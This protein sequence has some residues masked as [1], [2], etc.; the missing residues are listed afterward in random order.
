MPSALVRVFC[1]ALAHQALPR[2]LL[3]LQLV[4]GG[5]MSSRLAAGKRLAEAAVAAAVARG[6]RPAACTPSTV[7]RLTLRPAPVPHF[8]RYHTSTVPEAKPCPR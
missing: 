2:G 5:C 1:R 8:C 3:L 4:E 6:P 7:V